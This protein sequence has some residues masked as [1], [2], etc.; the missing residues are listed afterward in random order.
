MQTCYQDLTHERDKLQIQF[1]QLTRDHTALR[2]QYDVVHILYGGAGAPRESESESNISASNV[3]HGHSRS[4]GTVDSCGRSE[5][6]R[7]ASSRLPSSESES[8]NPN[9]YNQRVS[10]ADAL[11]PRNND[12]A[13]ANFDQS[14][15]APAPEQFDGPVVVFDSSDEDCSSS[16]S[17]NNSSGSGSGRST[18]ENDSDERGS[19][20]SGSIIR[21]NSSSGSSTG[22]SSDSFSVSSMSP[23]ND[24][25]KKARKFSTESG[26]NDRF[27]HSDRDKNT[28]DISQIGN[29]RVDVDEHGMEEARSRS[30]SPLND[31]KH[32]SGGKPPPHNAQRAAGSASRTPLNDP[33]H[34]KSTPRADQETNSGPKTTVPIPT[35]TSPIPTASSPIPTTSSLRASPVDFTNANNAQTTDKSGAAS[36]PFSTSMDNATASLSRTAPI[37][38]RKSASLNPRM[39]ANSGQQQQRSSALFR[40]MPLKKSASLTSRANHD[41]NTGLNYDDDSKEEMDEVALLGPDASPEDLKKAFKGRVKRMSARLELLAGVCVCVCTYIFVYVCMYVYIYIYI[42]IYIYR[43]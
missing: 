2:Q 20:S 24:S 6:A 31:E 10:G 27:G 37:P 3:N 32:S 5:A 18:T 19:H 13:T 30:C 22:P 4:Q 14:H 23:D 11:H 36:A 38:L 41:G 35:A 9:A 42:Y 43:I 12:G 28:H 15:F 34:S 29:V 21:A 1:D 26:E 25:R 40:S 8:N 33:T 17:S 7:Q 16:S 39:F